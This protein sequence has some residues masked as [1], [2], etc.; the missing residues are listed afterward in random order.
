MAESWLT[1]ITAKIYRRIPELATANDTLLVDD[2]IDE[3]LTEIV[4]YANAT[5]YSTEWDTLLVKC[6]STLYNYMGVEGSIKRQ[7][8]GVSD[9]YN[10]SNIL[11][12]LLSRNICPYIRP[13]GFVYPS[14]RFDMPE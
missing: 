13:V 4:K 11:S 1:K 10:S 7:A 2:L 5:A 14:T 12:E 3:A 8:N 6:V 9:T